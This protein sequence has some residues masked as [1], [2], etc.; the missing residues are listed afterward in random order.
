MK[1]VEILILEVKFWPVKFSIFWIF[2]YFK[3]IGD[4]LKITEI[5]TKVN[6]K[7]IHV[8]IEII[9]SL[10]V[11]FLMKIFESL[12]GTFCKQ[13]TFDIFENMNFKESDLPECAK[14]SSIAHKNWRNLY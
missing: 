10:H 14:K 3:K 13:G 7:Y 6:F 5:V 11:I 1:N 2:K 8:R 4:N 9:F 12:K